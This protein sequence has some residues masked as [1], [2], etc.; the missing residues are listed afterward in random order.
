MSSTWVP[1]SQNS[2]HVGSAGVGVISMRCAP[3]AL[4]TFATA[5]FKRFFD[6]GRA[7]RCMRPLGL[8]R[9]MHLMVLHGYQGA[10]TV[11]EQLALTDQLCDA[12]FGELGVVA[13]E[14]P[15]LLDG[16]FNV[17]PTKIPCLA[18]G[19]SAGLWVDFEECYWWS[20][21]GFHGWL[22]SCCCCGSF[23]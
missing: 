8:G 15:C 21:Q 9:F 10:D 12:A 11:A 22:P 6:Y 17:E 16:D 14:Q 4:P 19:I 7:V 23:L 3:L 1:A 5:E 2:S 13:G 18:K 20:S